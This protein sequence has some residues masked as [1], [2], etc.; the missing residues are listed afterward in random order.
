MMA[1]AVPESKTTDGQKRK[2]SGIQD[3]SRK[4]FKPHGK[5]GK[6]GKSGKPSKPFKSGPP[7]TA[8]P[9]DPKYKSHEERA[10]PTAPSELATIDESIGKMDGRFLAD[11]LAQ[12]AKAKNPDMTAIELTDLHIPGRPALSSTINTS[13]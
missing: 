13:R 10:Q 3:Q 11:Y 1:S 2:K 6:S 12:R 5:P 9:D 8:R 4:K 7:P